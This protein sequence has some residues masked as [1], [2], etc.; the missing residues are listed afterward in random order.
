MLPPSAGEAALRPQAALGIG[1]W[2][3]PFG[4]VSNMVTRLTG[5][6]QG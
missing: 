6:K 1:R 5:S 2:S 4:H 3:L